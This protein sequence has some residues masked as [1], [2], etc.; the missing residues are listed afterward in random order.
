[1]EANGSL[2]GSS[3]KSLTGT[4]VNEIMKIG[5]LGDEEY[6]KALLHRIDDQ[7]RGPAV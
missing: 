3:W 2:Y 4:A 7:Y 5:G 1:M 6:S